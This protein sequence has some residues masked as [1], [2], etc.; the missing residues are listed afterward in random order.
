MTNWK[1]KFHKQFPSPL[2]WLR[3]KAKYRVNDRL[4]NFISKE[5]IEKLIEDIPNMGIDTAT[6]KDNLKDK[7]L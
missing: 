6:M 4:Q 5:I 2:W 3:G 1:E 7:W